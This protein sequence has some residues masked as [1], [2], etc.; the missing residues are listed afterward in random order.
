MAN[1]NK[2]NFDEEAEADMPYREDT[3]FWAIVLL[4]ST[5]RDNKQRAELARK[6]LARLGVQMTCRLLRSG[7][8]C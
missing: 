2:V 7:N 4:R 1:V 5:E 6:N 3:G 8:L